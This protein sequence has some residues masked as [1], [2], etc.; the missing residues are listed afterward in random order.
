MDHVIVVVPRTQT[1]KFKAE[2]VNE[3]GIEKND[4]QDD[5]SFNRLINGEGLPRL[6]AGGLPGRRLP[7]NDGRM[8]LLSYL[9]SLNMLSHEF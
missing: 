4:L 1:A 2:D 8:S 7:R 9:L 5:V 6:Y 3:Y